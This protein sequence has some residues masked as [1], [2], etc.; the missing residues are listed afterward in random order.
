MVNVRLSSLSRYLAC[1]RALLWTIQRPRY[2]HQVRSK[3]NQNDEDDS[4]KQWLRTASGIDDT[5]RVLIR[6]CLA[7][8]AQ[9]AVDKSREWIALAEAIS[10]EKNFDIRIVRS[11]TDDADA[12]DSENPD[13]SERA[14]IE[15]MLK[16]LEA[17]ADFSHI[18]ASHLRGQL[19]RVTP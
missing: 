11:I 5:A 6:Y 4:T 3:V 15:D 18:L 13:D 9:E 17:F 12:L 8:A 10:E 19:E 16:R 1:Y 2:F 14:K 7:I